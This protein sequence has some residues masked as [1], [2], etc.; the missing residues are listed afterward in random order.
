MVRVQV[1][2]HPMDFMVDTGEEHS[3]VTQQ[4]APS[5]EKKLPSSGPQ[6][7]RPTG[8]FAVPDSAD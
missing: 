5:R 1:G 2:G 3:V 7:P 8:C 4:T 6:V